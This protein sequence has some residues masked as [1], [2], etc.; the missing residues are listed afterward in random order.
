MPKVTIEFQLPEEQDAHTLASRGRDYFS[1]LWE[2]DQWARAK[3]KHGDLT[4]PEVLLLETLREKI[5][6]RVNLDEVS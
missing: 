2:I 5:H 6:G 3:L 1:T 4:E